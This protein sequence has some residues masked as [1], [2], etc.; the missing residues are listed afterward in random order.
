MQCCCSTLCSCRVFGAAF[1]VGL[2]VPFILIY[3]FNWVIYII[4]LCTLVCKNCRNKGDKDTR[5]L[6][7]QNLLAAVMLSVL[8]G[9]GWGIGLAATTGISN[10]GVRDF[11][12]ALFII[13]TAFQGVMVFCLQTVRS[14]E[15]RNTW[16]KWFYRATGKSISDFTMST[17]GDRQRKTSSQ[18]YDSSV[19][20]KIS[21]TSSYLDEGSGTLQHSVKKSLFGAKGITTQR[22]TSVT[23]MDEDEKAA[24]DLEMQPHGSPPI[25]I[26]LE[27]GQDDVFNE[28]LVTSVFDGPETTNTTSKHSPLEQVNSELN[29]PASDTAPAQDDKDGTEDSCSASSSNKEET[30][31]ESQHT[32]ATERQTET[33]PSSALDELPASASPVESSKHD[34]TAVTE[35]EQSGLVQAAS[36]E[37]TTCD[38][39][40][41]DPVE[42]SSDEEPQKV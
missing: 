24:E 33:E 36:A 37:M 12:S 27:G 17:S 13:C 42:S 3:L 8:F 34:E 7:K 19:P 1:Y 9:L 22:F 15:V 25:S 31:E 11:F 28:E 21:T 38:E 39:E 5:K 29:K 4:I 35:S 30:I 18:P 40:K 2:I 14:K 16:S 10:V 23:E 26:S 6:V 32:A 20:R 41:I